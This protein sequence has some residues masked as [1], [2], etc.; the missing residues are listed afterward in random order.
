M[1]SSLRLQRI[2]DRIRQELSEMVI[3][4][5]SDPR[6]EGIFITDVKVDREL[7]YADIFVSA[8]E[9]VSRSKEVIHGLDHA[10]G[11]LRKSLSDR[12]E[13]RVFPRL[14]FHWDPTPEKAEHIETLL[15]SLRDEGKKEK[16]NGKP[17]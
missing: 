16:E 2:G 1:P 5:I 14:R 15:A 17:D 7:A 4:E 11:F 8:L 3:K 10:S 6:L 13:L 9:G 12:I